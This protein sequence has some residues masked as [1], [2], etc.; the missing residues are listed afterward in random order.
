VVY[1]VRE[2]VN[3]PKPVSLKIR[4]TLMTMTIEKAAG[5]NIG[6]IAPIKN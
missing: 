3:A 2:D 1:H 5:C 4:M 6:T